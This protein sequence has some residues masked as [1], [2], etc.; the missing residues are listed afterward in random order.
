MLFPVGH[1]LSLDDPRGDWRP[2]DEDAGVAMSSRTVWFDQGVP[3]ASWSLEVGDGEGP[4][5]RVTTVPTAA[6]DGAVEVSATD[7]GVQEGA[8]RF[9]VAGGRASVALVT[10]SPV[11]LDE[12]GR[13]DALT[14]SMRLD[15]APAAPLELGVSDGS[16]TATVTLE[17][18]SG[19]EAGEWRTYAVPVACFAESGVELSRVTSPF[20]L[21]VAGPATVSLA[22]VALGSEA[23]VRVSCD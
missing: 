16:D 18:V 5:T 22:R 7:H 8:R 14:F 19:P 15:E 9:A 21:G 23:D 12:A 4:T 1:G 2:L 10:Q 3:T 11:D 6:A 13:D 20:R 17:A